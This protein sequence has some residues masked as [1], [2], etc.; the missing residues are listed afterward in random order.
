MS[1]GRWGFK[2]S[3]F[4]PKG[5]WTSSRRRSEGRSDGSWTSF[6]SRPPVLDNRKRGIR[7]L[8]W[9]RHDPTRIFY[10]GAFG[11]LLDLSYHKPTPG[12]KNRAVSTSDIPGLC[13][14]AG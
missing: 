1:T 2:P 11:D 7:E 10:S 6:R 12:E 3:V 8:Q 13:K 5:V 14:I 9:Y 4:V